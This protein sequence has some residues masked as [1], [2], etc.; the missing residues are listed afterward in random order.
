MMAPVLEFVLS[1]CS[2]VKVLNKGTIWANASC[3]SQ[4]SSCAEPQSVKDKES[5]WPGA[6]SLGF[7]SWLWTHILCDLAQISSHSGPHL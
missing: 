2:C 1:L 6:R 5:D 7:M 4:V 3:L